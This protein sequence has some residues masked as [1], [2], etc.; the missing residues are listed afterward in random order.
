MVEYQK[1]QNHTLFM[2]CYLCDIPFWQAV[3]GIYM[4]YVIFDL[5][6]YTT[7]FVFAFM[8]FMNSFVLYRANKI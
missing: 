8:Y 7:N 2:F 5:L 1:L 3:I 6:Y 4:F